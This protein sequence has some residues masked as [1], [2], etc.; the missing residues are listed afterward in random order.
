MEDRATPKYLLGESMS[1]P[2]LNVA[3][4]ID[5]VAE[6]LHVAPTTVRRLI[7]DGELPARKSGRRVPRYLSRELA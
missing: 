4:T 5:Q 1:N 2:D 7:A 3:Y 6:A